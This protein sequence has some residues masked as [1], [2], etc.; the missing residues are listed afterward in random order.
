MGM[1]LV[2]KL[3]LTNREGNQCAG[4]GPGWASSTPMA[5]V[6]GDVVA[7]VATM[8]A[9]QPVTPKKTN[10]EFMEAYFLELVR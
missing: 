4:Y 7:A 6:F 9:M 10:A 8:V 3:A 1:A 2:L 5:V